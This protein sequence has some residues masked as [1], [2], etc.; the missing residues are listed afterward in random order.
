MPP[1]KSGYRANVGNVGGEP[2][3]PEILSSGGKTLED[4]RK[5]A[6]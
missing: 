2:V 6:T 4:L 3:L 1:R 5:E